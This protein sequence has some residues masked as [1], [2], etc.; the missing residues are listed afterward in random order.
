MTN[1]KERQR[2]YNRTLYKKRK[3]A[4]VCVE[5]GRRPPRDGKRTCEECHQ[6]HKQ[7]CHERYIACVEA[8]LCY[9][10]ET[11][12]ARPGMTAC[13]ECAVKKSA[14]AKILHARKKAREQNAV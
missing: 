6:K 14:Y 5:C 11:N 7:Y 13:F 4:G 12:A 2:V 9:I 1:D 8:G 10:C 3:E